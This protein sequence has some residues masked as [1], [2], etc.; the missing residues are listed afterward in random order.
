MR[1]ATAA[2]KTTKAR[3]PLWWM[4]RLD[5]FAATGLSRDHVKL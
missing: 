1:A 4:T 3:H 2:R 5:R